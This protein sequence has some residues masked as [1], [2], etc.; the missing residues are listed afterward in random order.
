MI[1]RL[2]A[3]SYNVTDL[4]GWREILGGLLGMEERPRMSESDPV[5]FRYDDLEYRYE[6]I[7][8]S[9]DSIARIIWEVDQVDDLHDVV[10]R[11]EASGTAVDWV[12]HGPNLRRD[13]ES[14]IRFTD[15]G[16]FPSEVRVGAT[17]DHNEF[18]PGNQAVSGFRTGEYGMGHVVLHYRDYAGA[19]KFYTDVLG[20][21]V[22]DYIVWADADATFFHVNGRHHSLAAMNECFGVEGGTFNH[23][24][25]EL[26]TVDDVGR[27]YDIVRDKK[28]PITMD[29]GRH[30]NDAMTSFYI[31][32]PSGW[33][34]EIGTGGVLVNDAEWEVRTW[35]ATARWGHELI[36]E[37]AIEG[38]P[39]GSVA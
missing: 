28:I 3:L 38:E 36:R 30:T 2:G 37:N 1:K 29:Y 26:N 6:L 33:Q 19:V 34:M 27:V 12:E 24:M 31:R 15:P 25:V 14:A 39:N 8:S 4:E 10:T 35:R 17:W 11:L 7:P 18:R 16:G 13:F 20:F 21:A 32:T 5:R 9:E 23:S 22:S